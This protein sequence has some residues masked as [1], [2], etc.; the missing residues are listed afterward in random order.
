MYNYMYTHTNIEVSVC[1]VCVKPL[2]LIILNIRIIT[3]PVLGMRKLLWN[4]W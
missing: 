4:S 1:K 3:I 2:G